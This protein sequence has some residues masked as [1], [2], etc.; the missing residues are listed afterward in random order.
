YLLLSADSF[1]AL[2]QAK[3]ENYQ[4][5]YKTDMVSEEVN[6][7]IKPMFSEIYYKL[8]DDLIKGNKDSVIFKHHIDFV[9]KNTLYYAQNS[10]ESQ[11]S[12]YEN[13]EPNR[14][15]SDFIASM[16]DDYFIELHEFLFPDS[17]LKINYKSYFTDLI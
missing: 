12:P 7:L 9:N 14:I 4:K 15:V 8:L 2:K 10:D 1:E 6:N 3:K 13:T 5:I 16:T 11:I 17:N